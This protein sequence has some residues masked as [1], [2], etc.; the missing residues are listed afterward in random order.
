MSLLELVNSRKRRQE[1]P[2]HQRYK[3]HMSHNSLGKKKELREPN[4]R[5]GQRCVDVVRTRLFR[6][7]G[8]MFPRPTQTQ[9]QYHR[10]CL[11]R[12]RVKAVKSFAPRWRRRGV[13]DSELAPLCV[14]LEPCT[15]NVRHHGF[16]HL[17]HWLVNLLWPVMDTACFFAV[18]ADWV[19]AFAN[20]FATGTA[21]AAAD[22]TEPITNEEDEDVAAA[23]VVAV[24][25]DDDGSTRRPQVVYHSARRRH[26]CGCFSCSRFES[27]WSL[28]SKISHG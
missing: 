1:R 2:P 11:F 28:Q 12:R 22:A 27:F 10:N 9:S 24:L 6:C 25:L 14:G 17:D 15:S 23:A 13:V 21:T 20:T 16:R 7:S 5:E 19:A 18:D 26:V 3:G 4:S 8:V